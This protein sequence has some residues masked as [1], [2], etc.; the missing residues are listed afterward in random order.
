QFPRLKS[1]NSELD[2]EG[3]V[4]ASCVHCHQVGESLHAVFRDDGN[5]IPRSALFPYPHPKILGLVMDPNEC[6]TILRVEPASAADKDGF[7][8][9]DKLISVEGQPIL[10]TAD[11]Q[12]VLHNAP[13]KG[14]ITISVERGGQPME[15][16]LALATGWRTRGD[17]SWR[18]TSWALRRMT[19]GGL[20]LEDLSPEQRAD[21][22]IDDDALALMAKHVG[23]YGEHAHAKKQGFVKGDVIVS[24][25]G[26]SDR[27]TESDLFALLVNRQVGEKVPVSVLR[28]S[29][30]IQLSLTMQK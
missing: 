16:T 4:A 23:E 11:I 18:A 20:Q 13:D 12:W 14:E 2:Y 3:N 1:Y 29:K 30:Q 5:P 9:G 7:R 27:M 6:A 15:L 25:A 17:I 24:I 8:A 10:S 26:K 28:G 21:R 19:T 22:Q